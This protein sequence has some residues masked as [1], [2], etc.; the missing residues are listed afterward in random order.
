MFGYIKPYIPDLR[1]REHEMYRAIYCGLCRSMGKHTGC[2]SRLTLSY[3]FVFLAA[4]RAVLGHDTVC[5]GFCRCAVHPLKKR[6]CI[7]D[8]ESL[9]YSASAAAVLTAAKVEDDIRDSRGMKKL[10]AKI[11]LPAARSSM[12]KALKNYNIPKDE[13]DAELE[14][15]TNLERSV[16]PS[17]DD[18]ADTFGR[19]LS[20][21]FSFGLP[22]KEARLAAE[23][24]MSAGRYIYVMDAADDREK[25][26]KSGNYNPLNISPMDNEAL[27]LAVRLELEK[28]ALS[29]ELMDYTGKPELENLIKNIIY[30]GLPKEADKLFG[31]KGK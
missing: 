12:K 7:A 18:T 28:M 9:K 2:L 1:V 21:I 8:C 23:I 22:E 5:P 31:K 17:L 19:L 24:G 27:S 29:A 16:S 10:A 13:I 15:L 26:K 25:D 4:V 20:V 30:E 11:L 3:D 6:S 14:K